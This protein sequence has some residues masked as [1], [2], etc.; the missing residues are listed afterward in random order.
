MWNGIIWE[1]KLHQY[2]TFYTDRE[3]RNKN[4][5]FQFFYLIFAIS[6][7]QIILLDDTYNEEE[8]LRKKMK[9]SIL[10]F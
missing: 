10:R 9:L 2:E 1:I 7:L 3:V 4:D 5:L 8:L 6:C